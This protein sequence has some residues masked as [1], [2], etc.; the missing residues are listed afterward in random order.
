MGI[1]DPAF[2]FTVDDLALDH[3]LKLPCACRVRTVHRRTLIDLVGRD[4]R[5]HL[6]GLRR[7]LWCAECGEPPLEGWVV[8]ETA[9]P[10]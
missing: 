5:L 9:L 7:E 3:A 8:C 2:K 1:M 10:A 6:I 4:A